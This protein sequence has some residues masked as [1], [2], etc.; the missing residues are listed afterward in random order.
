MNIECKVGNISV[1]FDIWNP[2]SKL[3]GHHVSLDTETAKIEAGR[4]PALVIASATDGV[5]GFFIA[6][7]H[8]P[9]FIKAH[10]NKTITLHNAAFD[11]A[12]MEQAGINTAHLI[13]TGHIFD[14][15]LL[16]RLLKL[17]DTG[18][19]H[20]QWSLVVELPVG[21]DHRALAERVQTIMIDEM[22]TVVPDL[23][24]S[25]EFALM[26]RWYKGAKA[27]HVNGKLVPVKPSITPQGTK[28]IHDEADN[29]VC[30]PQF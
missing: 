19:C 1:P 7:Q 24:V 21:A 23:P 14:T 13:K 12:V 16:Y 17:A 15:G 10:A 30:N 28:W 6:R 11:L 18:S 9:E 8:L 22:R 4:V 5:H 2:A 20:G 29:M 25:C 3:Q 27:L 26:R